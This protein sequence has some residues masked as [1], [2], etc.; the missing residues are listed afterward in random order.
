MECTRDM[1]CKGIWNV[2]VYGMY[3][4]MECKGNMECKGIWNVRGYGM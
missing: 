4:D 1:E 3:R 2:R